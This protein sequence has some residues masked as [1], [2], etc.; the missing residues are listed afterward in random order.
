MEKTDFIDK[1]EVADIIV[2]ISRWA[3]SSSGFY[4]DFI[5][6]AKIIISKIWGDIKKP[7]L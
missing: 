2:R 3:H 4:Q 7:V 5:P 6:Y 1:G